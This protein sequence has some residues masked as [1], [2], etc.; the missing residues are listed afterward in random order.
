MRD[1][2]ILSQNQLR[3]TTALFTTTETVDVEDMALSIASSVLLAIKRNDIDSINDI[4][5]SIPGN[6]VLV[7]QQ[8]IEHPGYKLVSL[9][10]KAITFE[11]GEQVAEA[12]SAM[13]LVPLINGERMLAFSI[14]NKPIPKHV[15][16][17]IQLGAAEDEFTKMA[18][19]VLPYLVEA[20]LDMFS[21]L[22]DTIRVKRELLLKDGKIE[23]P[24]AITKNSIQEIAMFYQDDGLRA[25]KESDVE[26]GWLSMWLSILTMVKSDAPSRDILALFKSV[27]KTTRSEETLAKQPMAKLIEL[28]LKC[29]ERGNN[30]LLGEI[31]AFQRNLPLL[32]EEKTF[33][34]VDALL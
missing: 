29:V 34:D 9:L 25:F 13:E 19:D 15:T 6:T 1:I 26:L 2:D 16:T 32:D 18:R 7:K 21:E 23:G 3:A 8:V 31:K 33:F 10:Y 28:F 17:R 14:L 12:L 27:L 30:E 20:A 11:S 24:R 4:L 5:F 22:G